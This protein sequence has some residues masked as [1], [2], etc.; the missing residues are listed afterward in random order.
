[1]FGLQAWSFLKTWWR[2]KVWNI[3]SENIIPLSSGLIQFL[4]HFLIQKL[5]T[6]IIIA[7]IAL[8]VSTDTRSKQ[9]QIR[10]DSK[11]TYLRKR[12]KLFR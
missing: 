3:I 9:P 4:L 11:H 10:A 2:Q 5:F 1:M 6:L 8:Q 7:S 12:N